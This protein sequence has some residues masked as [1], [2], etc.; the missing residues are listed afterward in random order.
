MEEEWRLHEQSINERTPE[1]ICSTGQNVMVMEKSEEDD[2]L[3]EIIGGGRVGANQAYEGELN[4]MTFN[5]VKNA[6]AFARKNKVDI[7][8]LD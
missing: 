4:S 5:H 6:S 7:S 1:F 3:G 8:L 2:G